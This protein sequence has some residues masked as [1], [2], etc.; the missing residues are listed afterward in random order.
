MRSSVLRRGLALLAVSSLSACGGA[1]RAVF[2]ASAVPAPP[3]YSPAFKRGLA[4]E[5]DAAPRSVLIVEALT[6]ASQFYDRIRRLKND[7]APR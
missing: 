6:D 3:S 4:A 5:I 2:D 7:G 1:G